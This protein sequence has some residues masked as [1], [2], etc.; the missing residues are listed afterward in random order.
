MRT[1]WPAPGHGRT[2]ED[3]YTNRANELGD[4][5]SKVDGALGKWQSHQ[6]SIFNGPHVWSGD[7]SNSA[8]AAVDGATKA[9]QEHQQQLRDARE[10]CKNAATNIG[11]VKETITTNVKA[12]QQE[13]GDIEKTA[14]RTNHSPDAAIR[15]VVERKYNEN[16]HTIETL[17]VGLGWK[18][19][20]SAS[21]ADRPGHTEPNSET[22]PAI[23]RGTRWVA[24]ASEAEVA[25]ALQP[26]APSAMAATPRLERED[27]SR[28]CRT[29]RP[30]AVAVRHR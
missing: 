10:W 23:Q 29:G 16:V 17:A 26:P 19:D 9:L 12:G 25:P 18:P 8:G 14:A 21:P 30:A 6:A 2:D 13:I 15:A 4:I 24:Q 7:A 27:R 3:I 5:L 28:G 1:R 20:I 22:G 11:N